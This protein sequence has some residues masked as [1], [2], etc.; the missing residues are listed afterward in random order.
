MSLCRSK[1]NIS[2]DGQWHRPSPANLIIQ[3]LWDNLPR[4]YRLSSMYA[5][6]KNCQLVA[7]LQNNAP[8]MLCSKMQPRNKQ[9]LQLLLF[10]WCRCFRTFCP[11]TTKQ[12]VIERM[13]T[14][15]TITGMAQGYFCAGIIM[16]RGT[17]TEGWLRGCTVK[18]SSRQSASFRISHYRVE[19]VL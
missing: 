4:K 16:E 12:R 6:L 5:H 18:Q 14:K 8:A 9:G 17:N 15:A 1:H 19:H 10:S 13:H 11:K 7:A 3:M 2:K